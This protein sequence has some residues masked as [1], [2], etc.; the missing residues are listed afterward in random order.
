VLT[1]ISIGSIIGMLLSGCGRLGSD[2][3]GSGSVVTEISMNDA[4]ARRLYSQYKVMPYLSAGFYRLEWED[5][6]RC[7]PDEARRLFV[8]TASQLGVNSYDLFTVAMGEG[9]G[10][11]FD[12]PHTRDS[13]LNGP[14]DGYVYLGVDFFISDLPGFKTRGLLPQTFSEGN[15]F[16]VRQVVRN[17]P[18]DN[19]V[20][21]T[22]NVPV[23]NGLRSALTAMGAYYADRQNIARRYAQTLGLGTLSKDEISFWSYY[24]YQNPAL[25]RSSMR[26]NGKRVFATGEDSV[27]PK[28]IRNKSA[29]RV[30]TARYLESYG[31]L[32]SGVSCPFESMIVR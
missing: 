6:G 15:Q 4:V 5:Y 1:V 19:G 22:L 32:E 10:F 21:I 26:N 13:L 11:Y 20:P 7:L 25:A 23:F 27:R 8:E 2:G 16:S 12:L 3:N 24:F 17:E 18:G 29:K 14:V 28:G 30:V 9:I 31:V